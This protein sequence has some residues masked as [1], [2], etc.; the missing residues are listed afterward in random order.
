MILIDLL[1]K[2]SVDCNI[3]TFHDPC[4]LADFN[5]ET[6][7]HHQNFARVLKVKTANMC[8]C[9]AVLSPSVTREPFHTAHTILLSDLDIKNLPMNCKTFYVKFCFRNIVSRPPPLT[10]SVL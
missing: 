1:E 10:P 5:V 7:G 4:L 9:T 3:L 2:V 8:V 6:G